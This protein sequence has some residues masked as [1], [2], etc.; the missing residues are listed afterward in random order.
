[1]ILGTFDGP[2]LT[3]TRSPAYQGTHGDSSYYLFETPDLPL[4]APLRAL[5]MPEPVIDVFEPVFRWAVELGYDRSI[6]P[7]EPTPARLFPTKVE[8]AKVTTD[9]VNAIGEGVTNALALVGLHAPSSSPAAPRVAP[10]DIA[11]GEDMV[12]PNSFRIV[13]A[14][15]ESN[16]ID[17]IRGA[18]LE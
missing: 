16:G 13:T 2:E 1:V 12:Q 4:F 10:E 18:E 7:W 14:T 11:S 8:P 9:L 5:G 6:K 3:D 17:R 15:T